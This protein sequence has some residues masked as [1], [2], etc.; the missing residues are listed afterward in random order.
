MRSSVDFRNK[1]F[2]SAS[3]V[4]ARICSKKCERQATTL[5]KEKGTC[6]SLCILWAPWLLSIPLSIF[7]S[8]RKKKKKIW[9]SFTSNWLHFSD[10]PHSTS[11]DQLYHPLSELPAPASQYPLLRGLAKQGQGPS[12]KLL[13]SVNSN[14]HLVSTVW[15]WQLLASL[16]HFQFSITYLVNLFIKMPT[17]VSDFLAGP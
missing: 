7:P 1:H 11:E 3:W 12:S 5:S 15:E 17:M 9:G 16:L 10:F 14:S 6:F 2:C 8:I 13:S 4:P